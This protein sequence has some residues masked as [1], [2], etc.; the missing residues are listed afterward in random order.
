MVKAKY[1]VPFLFILLIS[2]V[3]AQQNQ[4]FEIYR[5][6]HAAIDLFDKGEFV[7]AKKHPISP[8]SNRSYP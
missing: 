1:I 4:S 8:S 2:R 6:Y 5:T 7:A 3:N